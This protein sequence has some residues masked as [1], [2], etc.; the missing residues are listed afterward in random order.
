MLMARVHGWELAVVADTKDPVASGS[1]VKWRVDESRS[2]AGNSEVD[3]SV[4]SVIAWAAHGMRMR[5]RPKRDP[6]F[7]EQAAAICC[8]N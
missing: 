4:V 8:S 2:A 5:R 7:P 1:A 3:V 6:R